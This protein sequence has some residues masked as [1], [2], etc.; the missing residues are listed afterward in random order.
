MGTVTSPD[1]LLCLAVD[2]LLEMLGVPIAPNF[3]GRQRAFEMC[4]IGG[5]QLHLGR[6]DVLLE[7]R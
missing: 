7:S 4:E 5:L 1:S 3:D 2:E 6:R